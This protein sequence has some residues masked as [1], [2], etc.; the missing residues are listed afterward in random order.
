MDELEKW[1]RRSA[2]DVAVNAE[3]CK[4]IGNLR[5]ALYRVATPVKPDGR[6]CWCVQTERHTC[7]DQPRCVAVRG[8][9]SRVDAV[10][11]P[12]KSSEISAATPCDSAGVG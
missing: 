5:A 6:P 3:L 11:D 2:L 10:T 1:K 8:T 12:E 4:Q 9:L 7:M